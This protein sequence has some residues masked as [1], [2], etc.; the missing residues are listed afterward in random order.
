M[1]EDAHHHDPAALAEQSARLRS[2]SERL[3][4]QSAAL[5]ERR[6]S[7]EESVASTM[8][9]AAEVRPAHGDRLRQLAEHAE[10]T[11]RE[12]REHAARWAE[13]THREG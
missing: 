9:H 1:S 4:A 2:E 13:R 8:R 10:D 3:A 11:A 5:A 12:E 6:A 7:T